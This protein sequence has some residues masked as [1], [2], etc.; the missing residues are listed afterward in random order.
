MGLKYIVSA[1]CVNQNHNLQPIDKPL[2]PK[3][4]KGE[5]TTYSV[6]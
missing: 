5:M 2:E 1:T 6:M 4:L 3:C